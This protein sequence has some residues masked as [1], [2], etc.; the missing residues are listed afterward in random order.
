MSD[1]KKIEVLVDKELKGLSDEQLD[2]VAS[3]ARYLR[4]K[5]LKND[6]TESDKVQASIKEYANSDWAKELQH[7]EEE[8]V[9]YKT[10]FPKK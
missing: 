5:A 7:L 9:G 3:F 4:L 8:F 2:E 6:I 1:P 10:S